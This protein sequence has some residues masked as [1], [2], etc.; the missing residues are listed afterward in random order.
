MTDGHKKQIG[1]E[2]VKGTKISRLK[3]NPSVGKWQ[4]S[5]IEVLA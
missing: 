3:E 1:A 2:I 4:T 5:G